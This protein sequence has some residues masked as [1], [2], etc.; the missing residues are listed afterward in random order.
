M[1]GQ[2]EDHLSFDAALAINA[3]GV[4][5]VARTSVDG[6]AGAA[7]ARK[8]DAPRRDENPPANSAT[9]PDPPGFLGMAAS[10]AGSMA[11]FASSGFKTLP[12]PLVRL[13]L[14]RC[15]P[16]EYRVRTRCTL[17]G[18]FTGLKARLRDE[19]CPIGRWPPNSV[20]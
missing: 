1:P 2:P 13:R 18:C 17:C 3:N 16:C 19:D 12:G 10:F 4:R 5:S 7:L 20:P 9:A 14:Q 8:A 11:R 15:D 6:E